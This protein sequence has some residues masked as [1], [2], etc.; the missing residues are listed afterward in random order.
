[1][2]FLWEKLLRPAAF[3]F[4]AEHA[5]DLGIR[6]L[7]HGLARPFYVA[8]PAFGLDPFEL[9]GLRFANPLGIAAGFDKNGIVTDQLARLGFGFIEAGTVTLHPQ[10]GN[11]KPRMFRLPGDRALINRLG[12]NNLGAAA[13]V[14]NVRENQRRCVIGINIGKNKNVPNEEAVEAFAKTFE[15][16]HPVADYIAINVSSPNTP[17]LRDLQRSDAFEPLVAELQLR[18]RELGRKPLLVKIAPD[19]DDAGIKEITDICID[20]GIDGMIA[21]NTTIARGSLRTPNVEHIGDG[22]LSGAPLFDRSNDVIRTVFRHSGGRMPIIGVGGVFTANDA[23]A[24]I[25]AG[26][27][28]IQ[29]YTGFVYGGPTFAKEIVTG[30]GKILRDRG[31][32][33]V[34]S[35]VGCGAL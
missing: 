7:K 1:M 31:F 11:P 30:L 18:N 28:L 15:I 32:A 34:E 17:G 9:F 13:L 21:T 12:F 14:A 29:A 25:S 2:S 35:A 24:K 22:G 10:P 4:E 20:A 5:H 26:A 6:A 33:D 23:F 3:A 27:S 19:L 16:V 8:D